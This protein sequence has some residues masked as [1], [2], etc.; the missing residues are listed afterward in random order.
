MIDHTAYRFRVDNRFLFVSRKNI[1]GDRLADVK[2]RRLYVATN[3]DQKKVTFN[4]VQLPSLQDQQ[5][6]ETSLTG[7][8]AFVMSCVCFS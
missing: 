7:Y 6:W 2:S 3:Y 1:T 5:V 4:E 8:G